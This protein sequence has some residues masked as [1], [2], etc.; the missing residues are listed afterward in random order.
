MI[1]NVFGCAVHSKLR[2]SV[3]EA[4]KPNMFMVAIFYSY[5]N[6]NIQWTKEKETEWT[7]DR[8]KIVYDDSVK[9]KTT[10]STTS[11][12][13]SSMMMMSMQTNGFFS[14]TGFAISSVLAETAQIIIIKC[15]S[16]ETNG[17]SHM[18]TSILQPVIY[19][20]NTHSL[21]GN[22]ECAVLVRS[23][24]ELYY[25]LILWLFKLQSNTSIKF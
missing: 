16:N 12:L 17:I 25:L 7:S 1:Y 2:S 8:K 14:L 5:L 18:N 19:N 3:K 6:S 20:I 15:S 9:T 24:S 13:S 11:P 23:L 4:A 21:Q 22:V 10:S